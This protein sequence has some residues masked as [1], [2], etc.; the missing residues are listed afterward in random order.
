MK[1]KAKGDIE[2]EC[3][4]KISSF[5]G[6]KPC[7]PSRTS[8]LKRHL[9]RKHSDIF[10]KVSE[11][12]IETL[13]KKKTFTE[14]GAASSQQVK[15]VELTS[16]LISKKIEIAMTKDAFISSIIEIVVKNSFLSDFLPCLLLKNLMVNLQKS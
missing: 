6:G 9:N 4:E 16:F 12:D 3:G 8:N 13:K 14:L 5:T 11:K 1:C 7:S 10:I 2:E 15:Q